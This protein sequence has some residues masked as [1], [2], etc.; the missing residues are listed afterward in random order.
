MPHEFNDQ[1]V[2]VLPR[3]RIWALALTRNS[4]AADDL[5]QDAATKALTAQVSFEPGTN[6]SAWIHRIMVNHFLS[7]M[8]NRRKFDNADDLSEVP[9]WGAQEDRTAIRE[10]D[11]AFHRLPA[12]Q[13]QAFTSVV[14]LEQSYEEVSEATG[15]AIGTL[16][17]RVHRARAQLRSYMVGEPSKIAA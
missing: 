9:V 11:R 4:A 6:F 5:T 10:L 8:R 16:K 1:L 14:L 17:S 13:R 7:N 15:D 2:S 3:M 12:D